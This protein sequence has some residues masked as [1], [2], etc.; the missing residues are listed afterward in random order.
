MKN[1]VI[2][3]VLKTISPLNI[4]R[5]G[6]DSARFVPSENQVRYGKT[7]KTSFPVTTT[8]KSKFLLSGS[9]QVSSDDLNKTTVIEL[10]VVPATKI[11]GALRRMAASIV[12]DHLVNEMNVKLDY[13]TY[14]GM[15][16]GAVSG[17][18]DGKPAT[19]DEVLKARSHVMYG[20]FGGGPRMLRGNLKARD[21]LPVMHEL[22]EEQLIPEQFSDQSVRGLKA[23]D[24]LSYSQVIRKD[25]LIGSADAAERASL[26]IEDFNSVYDDKRTEALLRKADKNDGKDKEDRDVGIQSISMREDVIAGVPFLFHMQLTGTEAQ[27]GMLI[28]ALERALN[29][30][31][32]SGRAALG[33]GKFAGSISI[34]DDSGNEFY[35]LSSDNDGE[36][37]VT[38]EANQYIDSM[39]SELEN[40]DVDFLKS[41]MRSLSNKELAEEKK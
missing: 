34:A 25:D 10:P 14:M 21:A 27:L 31:G 12:E 32:F 20:I 16:V 7:D 13:Q 29:N 30:G 38:E 4:V 18:P 28:S 35:A 8:T 5:V 11:R 9:S 24:L 15:R 23:R 6:D 33:F 39:T 41:C 36:F 26:V 40:L 2:S 1:Y 37:T 19:A 17:R 3:G 22:I